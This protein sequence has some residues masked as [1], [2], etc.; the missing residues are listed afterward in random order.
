MKDTLGAIVALGGF[1]AAC[2]GFYTLLAWLGR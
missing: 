2:A 1:Y